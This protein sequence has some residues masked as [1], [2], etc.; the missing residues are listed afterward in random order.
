MEPSRRDDNYPIWIALTSNLVST[1][2]YALGFLV[3]YR[4]G[5]VYSFA[6]I[7]FILTLEFRLLKYHCI[8]CYYWGKRCGFGKGRVSALFFKKG[9]MSKFCTMNITWKSM[10]PDLLVSLIPLV[11]G[12]VLLIIK[13]DFILL[14]ILL[15][16]VALATF[17]N[18]FIR[19]SLTCSRCRQKDAGCPAYLLF[20]KDK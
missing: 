11:V 19:G 9:D 13:F 20:N 12:I 16:I 3:V 5:L 7:L 2:T 8:D 10:I 17:G 4:L 18:S 15:L 6:Y 14:A 1:G